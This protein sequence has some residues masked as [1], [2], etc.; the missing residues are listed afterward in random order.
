MLTAGTTSEIFRPAYRL[1]PSF[2]AIGLQL[3]LCGDHPVVGVMRGAYRGSVSW[4]A[5]CPELRLGIVLLGNQQVSL[6]QLGRDILT[7]VTGRADVALLDSGLTPEMLARSP[8]TVTAPAEFPTAGVFT[9]LPKQGFLGYAGEELSLRRDDDRLSLRRVWRTPDPL[10]NS[11]PLVPVAGV[12]D[13]YLMRLPWAT[14]PVWLR[15]DAE[16]RVAELC[17]APFDRFQ[18][19]SQAEVLTLPARR[20]ASAVV[21]AVTWLAGRLNR[22]RA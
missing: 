2:P 16:G 22:K 21:G 3:I 15:R 4:I 18:R 17:V 19:L 12:V 10:W 7:T 20:A 8:K 5:A 1:H 11:Q 14:I 9:P 6:D 13:M